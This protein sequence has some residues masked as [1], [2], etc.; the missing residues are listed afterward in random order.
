MKSGTFTS[1]LLLLFIGLKLTGQIAWS[2]VWVL[3]PFWIPLSVAAFAGLL[4][5]VYFTWFETEEQRRARK[6]LSALDQYS[7]SLK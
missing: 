2:W 4:L 5:F 6:I 1:L 7:R 3:A